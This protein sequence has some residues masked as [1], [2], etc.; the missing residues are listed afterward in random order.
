[1]SAQESGIDL[2]RV[3]AI[4][5][6]ESALTRAKQMHEAASTML[7][8]A[9][10]GNLRRLIETN[11]SYLL[12]AVTTFQSLKLTRPPAAQEGTR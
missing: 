9:K 7:I 4:E 5:E 11:L 6:L 10:G 2:Q 12:V 8:G 1:M 3:A